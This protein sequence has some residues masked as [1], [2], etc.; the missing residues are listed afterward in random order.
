MDV[1]EQDEGR[2][3]LDLLVDAPKP[4]AVVDPIRAEQGEPQLQISVDDVLDADDC[5]VFSRRFVSGAMVGW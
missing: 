5:S 1:L 3:D 4:R 2:S